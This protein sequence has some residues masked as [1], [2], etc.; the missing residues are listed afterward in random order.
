MAGPDGF[1]P[2]IRW[3]LWLPKILPDERGLAAELTEL[4]P[5]VYYCY[6]PG[7]CELLRVKDGAAVC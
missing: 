4:G 5:S 1:V 6:A 3:D 7:I 2:P